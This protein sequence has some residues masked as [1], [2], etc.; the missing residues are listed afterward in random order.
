MT[1][2]DYDIC[3]CG[4]RGVH[5]KCRPP[6]PDSHITLVPDK[7]KPNKQL[8]IAWDESQANILGYFPTK[9]EAIQALRDHAKLLNR[10]IQ[11]IGGQNSDK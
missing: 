4:I 10:E 7:K 8:Y 11:R 1:I 2:P 6:W 9:Q 3:D 5:F